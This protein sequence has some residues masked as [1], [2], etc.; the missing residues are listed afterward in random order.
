MP[1][2]PQNTITPTVT[3]GVLKPRLRLRRRLH[4]PGPSRTPRTLNLDLPKVRSVKVQLVNQLSSRRS[5]VEGWG[6][7]QLPEPPA[8]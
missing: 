8:E 5:S 1:K 3:H 2:R 4:P 6:I 7:S